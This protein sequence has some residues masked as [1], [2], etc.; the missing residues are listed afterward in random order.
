MI[1]NVRS[2]A[3]SPATVSMRLFR[4]VSIAASGSS[5]LAESRAKLM[6]SISGSDT[7]SRMAWNRAVLSLKC[8]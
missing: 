3:L 1:W 7:C 2:V 6:R 4:N 5:S 8:Q